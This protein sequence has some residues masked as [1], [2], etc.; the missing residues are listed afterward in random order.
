M[1]ALSTSA[2]L[3]AETTAEASMWDTVTVTSSLWKLMIMIMA[4][5][6]LHEEPFSFFRS[7]LFFFLFFFFF[8][9]DEDD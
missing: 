7:S 8:D 5:F 6:L 1:N 2:Q 9:D 4:A 3:A